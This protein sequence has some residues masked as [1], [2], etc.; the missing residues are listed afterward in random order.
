[1]LN[2]LSRNDMFRVNRCLCILLVLLSA[3][4][5]RAVVV[6]PNAKTE[7]KVVR[8]ET[9]VENVGCWWPSLCRA[10][11]GDLL[12][13]YNEQWKPPPK[14]SFLK[15]MRS[16]DEGR[17]WSEPTIIVR[18]KVPGRN[19]V[20]WSGLHLMPDG[21]LIFT[22]TKHYYPR[23]K[24]ASADEINPKKLW[25]LNS[26][27]RKYEAYIIRSSDNGRTWSEPVRIL[28]D[29]NCWAF[30]RPITAKDGSVLVPL[31]PV[32]TEP[33]QFC[34]AY[35][36]STDSGKTWSDPVT[37]AGGPAGYTEVT[38]GAA[39]NGDIVAILRDIDAGPRRQFCQAVSKDNGKTWSEPKL[40]DVWGK[41]PDILVLPSGRMLLAVGSLDC[42]DG[43]I[44]FKGPLN[45]SYA[46]LFISDD[47]SQTW[48]RDVLMLSQDMENLIPFDSPAMVLLKNENIL[49]VTRTADRRLADRPL[50]AW[51]EGYHHVINE[52]APAKTN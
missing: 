4:I 7:Y 27:A 20:S 43:S 11:N 34:S 19:I 22:Y 46:G 28:P 39:K 25:D 49:V 44:V 2:L 9:L 16:A 1:M 8:I 23:R 37:I 14:C 51:A 12:F 45:S 6:D 10:A 31:I 5:C 21:S 36:R 35:V 52:L 13:G 47:N 32:V 48:K 30:G 29:S 26:P 24:D 50:F 18:S 3:V 33:A 17:T 42:M 41:M 38:L 15:L 40:I